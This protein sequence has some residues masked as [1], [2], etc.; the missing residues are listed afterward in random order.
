[1]QFE[2]LAQLGGK[3]LRVFQVL[4]AQGAP[5]DLVFVGGADAA[6]G[7]ADLGDAGFFFSRFAGNVE[8]RVKRQD[9]GAGF[10]DAQAR[11]HLH[12][13]FFQAFNF[14]KQFGRRQH[15]AVADVALHAR[16]HDA[17]G[18]QVQSGLDAV[19]DQRVAG[20]VSTLKTHHALRHFG[21]PVHQL[22][23]AFVTPLGSD[24][25]NIAARS[26]GVFICHFRV[27]CS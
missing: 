11:T 16:A 10:A 4:Y 22:A 20:I 6:A 8:R 12:T 5:G 19:D 9:Q 2:Q 18:D 25:H 3:T 27:T 26:C 15:H 7:G 21:E 14:F 1:M 23:F 17:A 24:D 13:G